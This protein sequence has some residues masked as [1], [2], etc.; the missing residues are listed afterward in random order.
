MLQFILGRASSGKT[1][2]VIQK[3]KDCLDSGDK[4]VLLVPEQFSFES[5]KNILDAVGDG[6]AQRV[7]VISFTRLCDEIE[8]VNGGVCGESITNADRIIL[9]TRAIKLCR[10]ELVRFKKYA[11]SSS[12]ARLMIDTIGEFKNEFYNGRGF[13]RCGRRD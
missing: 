6:V 13:A 9:M 5:E 11:S 3:I 7:S 4:P 1:Y 10:D 12:F 8:R 2:T